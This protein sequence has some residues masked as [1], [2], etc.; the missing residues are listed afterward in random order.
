VSNLLP[1]PTSRTR[2]ARP[3]LALALLA[4]LCAGRARAD[5]SPIDA[6]ADYVTRA[7]PYR[8]RTVAFPDDGE[9][10]ARTRAQCSLFTPLCVHAEATVTPER[11]ARTL[12]ALEGARAFLATSGWPLPYPDEAG[13]GPAFDLYLQPGA[14]RPARAA[15]DMPLVAGDSELDAASTFAV[16]DAGLPD[17]ALEACALSALVQAGLLG[18]DP[19]E[20]HAPLA[21]ASLYAQWQ[22][23][24]AIERSCE[25][26]LVESQRAP[27]VGLLG[28]DER[29][30]T[31]AAL[32]LV[33]LSRRHDGGSG[34]FV[35]GL[36]ELARQRSGGP[37]A[38]HV[39]PSLRSALEAALERAGESPD[40]SAEELAI[41]RAFAP[42]EAGA[43]P[44]LPPQATVPLRADLRL[45]A[46]P[47]HVI[48]ADPGLAT[49]GSAYVRVDTVGAT[50]GRQLDVWLRGEADARW[51]LVA[52]RLDAD[53]RERSRMQ[54]PPRRLP[55][56][57]LPVE[58]DPDTHAVLLVV[59]KLP[60][61][62]DKKKTTAGSEE[63]RHYFRLIVDVKR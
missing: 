60:R 23:G 56:S 20:Q 34:R 59:T 4:G 32:Q 55:E 13:G 46:L 54:A 9:R 16:L 36:F 19:A 28:E 1:K 15:A 22:Y 31:A 35:R 43:L 18:H 25:G 41:A 62:G 40:R 24:L 48:A 30:I 53:G 58:L 47:K 5:K 61:E 52:V 12:N 10:P 63:D 39:E 27:E 2:D 50:A 37:S 38:L 8:G 51:S 44:R 57:F 14:V 3:W 6:F 45:S 17:D 11:V 7:R 21:A 33:L 49:Y 29:A 26:A 42:S